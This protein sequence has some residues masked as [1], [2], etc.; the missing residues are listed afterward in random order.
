MRWAAVFLL[1]CALDAQS[2]IQ[3]TPIRT[4]IDK[5]QAVPVDDM[6]TGVAPEIA[7]LHQQ[8]KHQLRD[9]VVDALNRGAD[10]KTEL[11]KA[12]IPIDDD[13]SSPY[14]RLLNVEVQWKPNGLA[15]WAE[16]TTSLSVMCGEDT[17]LYLLEREEKGWQMRLVVESE[18]SKTV[19]SGFGMFDYRV[20]PAG[21]DDQFLIVATNVN[22]SCVSVW[23]A[24]R[25]Q[26]YS[27]RRNQAKPVLKT[28]TS[29]CIEGEVELVVDEAGFGLDYLAE[30]G[31]SP[32]NRRNHVWRYSLQGDTMTRVAPVAEKPE[33]FVDEWRVMPWAAAKRWSAA[34][35][36]SWHAKFGK[37][38]PFDLATASCAGKEPRWQVKVSLSQP[39]PGLDDDDDELFAI[40]TQKDGAFYLESIDTDPDER[41]S[42]K[43]RQ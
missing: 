37:V 43:V 19:T 2:P 16:V 12:G 17:S 32:G 40:V 15:T 41:C 5:L 26:A 35:L 3:T 24:L 13:Q 31:L 42:G 4:T 7:R 10:V 18:F 34:S 36:E 22:P 8:L 30:Q 14:G 23:Q 27:L 29:I 6:D 33:D 9:F 1:A 21:I 28:E 38:S 20:S 39:V 25:V 11:D